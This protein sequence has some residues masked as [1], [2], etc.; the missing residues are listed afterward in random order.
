MSLQRVRV[1]LVN[2]QG[3]LNVGAV[4]RAMK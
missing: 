1:V 3:P 4:A 2:P